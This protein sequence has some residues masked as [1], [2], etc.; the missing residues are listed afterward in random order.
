M[1]ARAASVHTVS[2]YTALEELATVA[3]DLR[4]SDPTIESVVSYTEYS[5][6]GAT[7]ISSMLGLISEPIRHIAARDKRLMKH[8]VSSAGVPT[9]PFRSV[10]DPSNLI[11][12]RAIAAEINFPAVL[13]PAAGSGT[14]HTSKVHDVEELCE[15][16]ERFQSAP[17]LDSRKLILEEFIEG[18]EFHVDAAWDGESASF[19]L[20]SQYYVP[21]LATIS[22]D[23]PGDPGVVDGSRVLSR[24]DHT[25]LYEELMT[26]NKAVNG[27]L[28]IDRAVTH[29]EVFRTRD[30]KWVFSEI[31]TRIG[32]AWIPQLLS[33][34]IGQDIWAVAADS[35]LN[36]RIVVEPRPSAPH[37]AGV[38]LRPTKPGTIT[39][40]P[41]EAD[42][43]ETPGM[44]DYRV[45]RAVGDNVQMESASEYCVFAVIG[46]D[47]AEQLED[48]VLTANRRLRVETASAPAVD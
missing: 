22:D 16:A 41:S 44:L 10:P 31:A 37:L 8:F 40:L 5:Q 3:A 25:A 29:M 33:Q 27:A 7:Y 14:E 39:S 30:G 23:A 4:L 18:D 28:K 46:A 32:G 15:A 34:A 43:A 1:L 13:K 42:F 2:S 17:G 35:L 9:A 38:H 6:L 45:I 21:R 24:E 47:T 20:V 12:V 19:F 48:R 11:E 36:G 26:M